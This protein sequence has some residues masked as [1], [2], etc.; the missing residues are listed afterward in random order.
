MPS[1]FK[2]L[3]LLRRGLTTD[4]PDRLLAFMHPAGLVCKVGAHVFGR[5]NHLPDRM[6]VGTLKLLHHLLGI[7]GQARAARGLLGLG[8]TRRHSGIANT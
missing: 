3:G 6:Q 4:R 5:L 7:F 8:Q 1:S 2:G